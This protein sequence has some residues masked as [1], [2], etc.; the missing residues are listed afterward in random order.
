[1]KGRS[2][3]AVLALLGT[4]ACAL[5][6][7]YR[8]ASPSVPL[9]GGFTSSAAGVSAAE[10]TSTEWWRLYNDPAIDAL[11]TEALAANP[12]VRIALANLLTTRALRD[13]A[14][15]GR[16]PTTAATSQMPPGTD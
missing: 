8:P 2:V 3:F 10:P 11:V 1:M 6:P 15:A 12:D 16:L 4:A 5:G 14:A 9:P 13:E 7:D